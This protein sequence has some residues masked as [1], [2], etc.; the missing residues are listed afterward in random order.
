MPMRP[1][2]PSIDIAQYDIYINDHNCIQYIGRETRKTR[3]VEAAVIRNQEECDVNHVERQK[4]CGGE[5]N[6]KTRL[7]GE[8]LTKHGTKSRSHK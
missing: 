7:W 4:K 6:E 8:S 1:S 3:L 5:G 2:E